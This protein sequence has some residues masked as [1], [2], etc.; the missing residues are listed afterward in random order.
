MTKTAFVIMPF[1]GTASCTEQQW[2]EIYEKIFEPTM[3]QC[4]YTCT[5]AAPMT[6]N[7][8][9]SIVER[10]R[11]STIV[12]ADLTDANANVFYEL[13]IRHSLRKGTIIVAQ[14]EK[15]IPSDLQG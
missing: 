7:L 10:L 3:R 8:G 4:G 5:R 13:G 2:T 9:M 11:E 15:Y 6:G 14:H 12:F 1:S